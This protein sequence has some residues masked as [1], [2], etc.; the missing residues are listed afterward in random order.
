M[1][2]ALEAGLS[3]DRYWAQTPRATMADIW[4]HSRRQRRQLRVEA[5][6]TAAQISA[7][8]P[9]GESVTADDLLGRK[10]EPAMHWAE[11]AYLYFDGLAESEG[12]DD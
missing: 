4:G 12:D 2:H 10:R 1:L 3:H 5:S 8:M 6:M 7:W 11:K 9:E